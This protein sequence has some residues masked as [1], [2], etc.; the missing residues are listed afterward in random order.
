MDQSSAN[1]AAIPPQAV[2]VAV[3]ALNEE[4][5]I[6]ACLLSLM[7]DDP[8]MEDVLVVVADGGS[9]DR[10]L[11][12]VESLRKRFPNLHI[13]R[14][15]AKL[16]SA[17]VNAV[18]QGC[19]RSEH[20]ALVRCDA[21]AVYPKGY[22]RD[23]VA[24]LAAQPGAASVAV[25]MDSNGHSGFARAAA[26]VVD[27]KLGS[28]GSAHRGGKKSHW[29]DHAHHAAFRLQWFR[30]VGG[31]DASFSHNE[32][33]EYDHRLGLAG[34]R[35]WLDT[36]IR[37]DYHMR[38]TVAKL[39]KQYWNY[40]KGRARTILKHR[41]KPRVRQ[42]IPVIHVILLILTILLAQSAPIF[43]GYPLLYLIVLAGVSFVGVNKIGSLSGLWAGPALGAMHIAWGL[44]FL[45]QVIVAGPSALRK[46]VVS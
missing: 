33:A 41:M 10:T 37:L 45:R 16:Q 23:V 20:V 29:I 14:N 9:A 18:V 28:G 43:W 27:T 40:G 13:Q 3:P 39:A 46:A 30:K 19:A 5:A 25:P 36:D 31:Y 2:I 15:P 11:E 24:S 6:E 4:A 32:D 8:F 22:I 17:G 38:G 35:I 42:M 1:L 7:A 26:W 44:G 12:I 34:G 21:H